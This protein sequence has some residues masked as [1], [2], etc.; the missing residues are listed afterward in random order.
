[1]VEASAECNHFKLVGNDDGAVVVHCFDWTSLL[2]SHFRRI[3]GIQNFHHFYFSASN[4]G[5]A[6]VKECNDT[7]ETEF[8]LLKDDWVP[9]PD[10]YLDVITSK[11]LSLERQW[12]LYDSIRQF[13]P[14]KDKDI[15]CPLPAHQKPVGRSGTPIPTGSAITTG[16]SSHSHPGSL[17]T[18]APPAKRLCGNCRLPGHNS[19][20][21]LSKQLKTSIN[22][23]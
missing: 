13:C 2:C 19:R 6:V 21:C 16:E 12:Y 15:T 23:S 11:G 3:V 4:P 8:R 22:R 10:E 7:P 14:D 5:V 1:M 9:N 17:S 20:K 18:A